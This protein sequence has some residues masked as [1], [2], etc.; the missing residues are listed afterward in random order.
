MAWMV[1]TCLLL[2]VASQ[3]AAFGVQSARF[4]ESRQ[5]DGLLV[6]PVSYVEL[7]PMF[8]GDVADV[9]AFLYTVCA[10]A[11]MPWTR[12]DTRMAFVGWNEFVQAKRKGKLSRRPVADVLIGAFALRFQGLLTRNASDFRSLFPN[13]TIVEP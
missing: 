11:A 2:D 5:A 4:L 10:D 8:D 1:D 13:L 7:A 3:D 6:C 9:D 12:A